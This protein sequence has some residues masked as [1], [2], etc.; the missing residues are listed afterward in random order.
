MLGKV[1]VAV[2]TFDVCDFSRSA[3]TDLHLRR[4]RL[5]FLALMTAT[6]F[7]FIFLGLEGAL[8]NC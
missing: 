6:R 7:L 3:V 8:N 2:K 5:W 1:S 4:W